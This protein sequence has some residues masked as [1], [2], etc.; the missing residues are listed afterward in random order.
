MQSRRGRSSTVP[1]LLHTVSKCY[2]VLYN[3]LRRVV[4]Y[5]V[6]QT[7]ELISGY[8]R[9]DRILIDAVCCAQLKAHV[10]MKK[11]RLAYHIRYTLGRVVRMTSCMRPWTCETESGCGC[12]E[13]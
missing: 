4:G 5:L 10:R 6:D 11:T 1:E 8:T 3:I 2:I 9:V 7:A 13:L 12:I